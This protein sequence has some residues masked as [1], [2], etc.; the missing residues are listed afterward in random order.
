M[1]SSDLIRWGG[2][3]AMLAGVAFILE[4]VFVRWENA[5]LWFNVGYL[6]AALLMLVG[7]VGL[8]TL[9]KN[10]YGRSG[11]GG[12]WAV[13]VATLGQLLGIIVYL[14]GSAALYWLAFPVGFVV[15]TV[16]LIIY[17]VAT[18]QAKVLPRW[19]GL[20]LI[21]I[22]PIK[23]ISILPTTIA[24]RDYGWILF[25][26]LWL[27]LGYVLG[28]RRE[29]AVEQPSR[30]SSGRAWG[31]AVQRDWLQVAL[32]ALAG[33][34][35]LAV[36]SGAFVAIG[37]LLIAS[38]SFGAG[39][40]LSSE[41]VLFWAGVVTV[42]LLAGASLSLPALALGA[43]GGHALKTT[44]LSSLVFGGCVFFSVLSLDSSYGSAARTVS[45]IALVITSA[46]GSLVGGREEGGRSLLEVRLGLV[47]VIAA[48]A[49]LSAS[50]VAYWLVPQDNIWASFLAPYVVGASSW[51]VLPAIVA[52]LRS[53]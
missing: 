30:V 38:M 23:T 29:T 20:A 49:I 35:S 42:L 21:I 18:L 8:H 24:W 7:L 4:I 39:G 37:L 1:S 51:L 45:L 40:P 31:G 9:Q 12:F 44:L 16:G 50:L 33:L 17:G 41:P 28:L 6:I 14:L 53:G 48:G 22:P 25:G 5:S 26:L 43:R 19:C 34:G 52:M 46:V 11:R 13:V 3:A 10:N 47:I 32:A 36:C 27:A 15:V 2:L